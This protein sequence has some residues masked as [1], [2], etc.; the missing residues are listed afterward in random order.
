MELRS[1][2]SICVR[3]REDETHRVTY[4][5]RLRGRGYRRMKR[6]RGAGDAGCLAVPMVRARAALLDVRNR[7]RFVA[8]ET[9]IRTEQTQLTGERKQHREQTQSRCRPSGQGKCTFHLDLSY[10]GRPKRV[11]LSWRSWHFSMFHEA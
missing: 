3:A 1:G 7:A 2:G 10:P 4:R 5:D 8:S 6:K 11:A 9:Q